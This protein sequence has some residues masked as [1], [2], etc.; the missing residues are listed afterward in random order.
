MKLISALVAAF[1]MS[2]SMMMMPSTATAASTAYPGS[3]GTFCSFSVPLVSHNH[4]LRVGMRVRAGNAVPTGHVKLRLYKRTSAG[5]YK[6]VRA[7]YRLYSGGLQHFNFRNLARGRYQ[8]KYR[9]IPRTNAVFQSCVST[10]RS[11]RVT[12]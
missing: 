12:R 2:F 10:L 5:T 11:T 7:P 1:A 6:L 8:V 3:V 9:Y 4:H